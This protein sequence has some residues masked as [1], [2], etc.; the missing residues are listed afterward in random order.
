[1]IDTLWLIG[2]AL[3]GA[4]IGGTAADIDLAP[5]L[6]L[7]HRSAWTHGPLVPYGVL[8]LLP[9]Y[10]AWWPAAAAFLAAYALHLL[11]DM[12]PKGWGG[13]STIKLF[14]IPLAL[15]APLSFIYLAAGAVYSA[16]A[17]LSIINFPMEALWKYLSL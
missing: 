12:F 9:L 5:P 4:I 7:K 13:G 14:P 3:A 10:P 17:A 16:W 1:M 15:P 8:W 6:P 11:A 2:M